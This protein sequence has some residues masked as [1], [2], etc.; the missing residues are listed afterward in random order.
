MVEHVSATLADWQITE[1]RWFSVAFEMDPNVRRY[2]DVMSRAADN[3]GALF[4]LDLWE[5]AGTL[6]IV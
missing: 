3:A 5:P 2:R 4:E 1:V 6:G